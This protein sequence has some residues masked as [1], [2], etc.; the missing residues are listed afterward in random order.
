MGKKEGITRHDQMG[1]VEEIEDTDKE[2]IDEKR[3]NIQW[4]KKVSQC[5]HVFH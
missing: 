1:E 5:L 2:E 4:L 3:N